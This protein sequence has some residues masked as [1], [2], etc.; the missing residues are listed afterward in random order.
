MNINYYYHFQTKIGQIYCA[1]TCNG[2]KYICLGKPHN[3][4]SNFIKNAVFYKQIFNTLIID[5]NNYLNG[6]SILSGDYLIDLDGYTS[7]QLRVWKILCSVPYGETRSYRWV[8]EKL[9]NPYLAR[10][11]G[12]ANHSNPLPLVIP[13]HRIISSSGAL[14]GFSS[15]I[16]FKKKL[17]KLESLSGINVH[18]LSC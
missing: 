12:Q 10:A 1:S 17:L 4:F 8:A 16:E 5:L 18:Q 6:K 15:G 14:G 13:C 2:L 9:G 7:F 3:S 11:I